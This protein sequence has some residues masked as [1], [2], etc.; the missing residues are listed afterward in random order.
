MTSILYD[1]LYSL[2]KRRDP[3]HETD[4]KLTGE[5]VEA[6][7]VLYEYLSMKSRPPT[8]TDC[9]IVLGSN[10]REVARFAGDLC[11]TYRYPVIVFSGKSG[12][13]TGALYERSEAEEFAGIA[14]R[15]IPKSTL[16][17]LEEKATNTAE[18]ILFSIQM[19]K[20]RGINPREYLLVQNPTMT[21]RAYA[22]FKKLFPDV[23]VVCISPPIDFLKYLAIPAD[24]V[25]YIDSL[26]G[27]LQR[28]LV[29]PSMGFQIEQSV[30]D[31]VL[32][33]YKYLIDHGF[34][35]QLVST[36]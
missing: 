35:Q 3:M 32:S 5:I 11:A 14:G 19:V 30:P 16:V 18:N 26:V 29:Y 4:R 1:G 21:R 34:D 15:Q 2:E 7:R 9:V 36:K 22:T 13:N 24:G 23:L 27:N 8:S 28:I 12:R 17:F 25:H 31:Q 6:G 20:S 33:A 10:D